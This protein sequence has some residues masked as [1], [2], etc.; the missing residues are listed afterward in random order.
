MTKICIPHHH[1]PSDLCHPKGSLIVSMV[2]GFIGMMSQGVGKLKSL[3][4]GKGAFGIV[5]YM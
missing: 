2:V 1:F 5:H 3:L 4:G